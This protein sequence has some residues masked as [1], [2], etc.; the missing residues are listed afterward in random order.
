MGLS[1]RTL[2]LFLDSLEL[3][4]EGR[5]PDRLWVPEWLENA[6][7]A[8]FGFGTYGKCMLDFVCYFPKADISG[9]SPDYWSR[10]TSLCGLFLVRYCWKL[11]NMRNVLKIC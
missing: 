9:L 5:Y 1:F 10:M 6:F 7:Q 11:N 4:C 8:N 2:G 3:G